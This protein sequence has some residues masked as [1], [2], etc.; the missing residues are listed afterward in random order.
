MTNSE[1]K[2]EFEK[3]I[4]REY[5]VTARYHKQHK[6]GAVQEQWIGWKAAWNVALATSPQD[7]GG[8]QPIESA[9]KDGTEILATT[10]RASY[11]SW[12]TKIV[13]WTDKY[14]DDYKWIQ[15]SNS[16]TDDLI[17]K[18]HFTHWQPLPPPPQPSNAWEE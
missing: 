14:G 11:Q 10:F 8:W 2:V 18:T 3:W 13:S 6:Y 9:P 7:V 16:G 17:P 4:K 1:R 12:E 15:E 5:N